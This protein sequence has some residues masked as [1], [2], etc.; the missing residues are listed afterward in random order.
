MRLSARFDIFFANSDHPMNLSMARQL[1][2]APIML[3]HLSCPY[4]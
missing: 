2:T 1:S 4:W 3:S